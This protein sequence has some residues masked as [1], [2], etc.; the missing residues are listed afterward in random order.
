MD[1]FGRRLRAFRKLKQMTQAD[2]ARALG[3]SLATIGGIERGTRQPTE[4]LVHAIASALSVDAWELC[5]PAWQAEP[6]AAEARDA[7][8]D[9]GLA[10]DARQCDPGVGLAPGVRAARGASDSAANPET[11]GHLSAAEGDAADGLPESAEPRQ[12]AAM[13]R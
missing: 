11:E 1:A 4:H 5:G 10:A 12:D 7:A 3:V 2:L 6:E 9:A 8:G 13:V